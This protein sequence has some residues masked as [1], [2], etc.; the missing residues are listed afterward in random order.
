M[1]KHLLPTLL[2]AL[3]LTA[4]FSSD[5]AQAQGLV[6]YISPDISGTLG[7]NGIYISDVS[8]SWNIPVDAIPETIIGCEAQTLTQ[9]TPPEGVVIPCYGERPGGSTFIGGLLV[10]DQIQP[11]IIRRDTT[12]PVLELVSPA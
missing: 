7:N 8:I 9:D 4:T 6:E 3:L 12:P 11:V 1:K 10:D 5:P 2:A